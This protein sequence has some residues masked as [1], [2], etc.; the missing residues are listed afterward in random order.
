MKFKFLWNTCFS[1]SYNNNFIF[2]ISFQRK[3]SLTNERAYNTKTLYT[4]SKLY[5][6]QGFMCINTNINLNIN[7]I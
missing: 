6:S 7:I 3:K 4:V 5:L 1:T 2:L